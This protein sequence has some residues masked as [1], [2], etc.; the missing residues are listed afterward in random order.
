MRV[1][2]KCRVNAQQCTLSC[3]A[4][5]CASWAAPAHEVAGAAVGIRSS[6]NGRAQLRSGV[7]GSVVAGSEV[8]LHVRRPSLGM[9]QLV[10]VR[11]RDPCAA[12]CAL[13]CLMALSALRGM[14]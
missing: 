4:T 8:Q 7:D 9:Q 13:E 5:A 14:R 11:L 2:V 12:P 10:C 6:C 3:R 1:H